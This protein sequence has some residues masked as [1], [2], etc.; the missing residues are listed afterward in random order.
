MPSHAA[1]LAAL[2]ATPLLVSACMTTDS[3]VAAGTRVATPDGWVPV[4]QLRPGDPVLAVDVA[5]NLLVATTITEVRQARRECLEL[6]CG[7]R[8]LI[9]TPDHPIFAPAH[10][11]FVE[12]GRVALGQVRDVMIVDEPRVEATP[13]VAAVGPCRTYA[14]LHEVF[15][16]SVAGPHRT[17]VAAGFVVHNKSY[18]PETTS[19]GDPFS[20]SDAPTTGGSTSEDST[21]DTTS[22]TTGGSTGGTTGG[23]TGGGT[24]PCG[25]ELQCELGAE[26]CETGSGG[27]DPTISYACKPIPAECADDPTCMCLVDLLGAQT[28]TGEPATGVIVGFA[29]P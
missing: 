14:G 25:D 21:G 29:F 9:V 10:A 8:T 26:Y 12:A 3:C 6:T 5:G 28:C 4:E 1:I 2:S 11:D 22:G 17:F 15:D 18:A 20:T 19:S 13:R 27:I 23:T 7:A 16:L 24:F